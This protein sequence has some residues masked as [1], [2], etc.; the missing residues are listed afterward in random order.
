[1]D[2]VET[3]KISL[4]HYLES[5]WEFFW[6]KLAWSILIWVSQLL[7]WEFTPGII[8]FLIIYLAD[9]FVW[10]GTALYRNE[11]ESHKFLR[12][13]IKL[14]LYWVTLIVMNQVDIVASEWLKFFID[15]PVES[16]FF[17]FVSLMFMAIHETISLLWKMKW[18]WVPVPSIIVDR[19]KLYEKTLSPDHTHE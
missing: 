4:S 1:M 2:I 12:G 9:L 5:F 3:I 19:L 6:L 14:L 18:L 17:R 16:W 11:F 13:L 15:L 10:V 8:A 7:I